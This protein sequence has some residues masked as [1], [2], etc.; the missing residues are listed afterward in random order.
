MFAFTGDGG[1]PKIPR[2]SW[3]AVSFGLLAER[4]FSDNIGLVIR[5]R[6]SV[7]EFARSVGR[8]GHYRSFPEAG[9]WIASALQRDPKGELPEWNPD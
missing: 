9:I 8:R 7:A 2:T 1:I 5:K 3:Q 4:L 6:T